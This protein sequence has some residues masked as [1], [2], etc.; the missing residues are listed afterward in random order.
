MGN[1]AL[2]PFII[3]AAVLAIVWYIYTVCLGMGGGIHDVALIHLICNLRNTIALYAKPKNFLY[4][5]SSFLVNKPVSFIRWV[6]DITVRQISAKRL[7]RLSL[8]FEH[9]SDFTAGVLGIKFVE[10]ID[11]RRH[12]VLHLVVAVHAIIDGNKTDVGIGKNHLRVHPDFQVITT[13]AA[14]VLHN[15]GAYLALIHQRHQA[16]PVRPVERGAA[17]AIIDE[18]GKVG[19]AIVSSVLLQNGLLIFYAVAVPL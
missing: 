16:V 1:C 2:A 9:S 6:F 8:G 15:N 13:E 18:K 7:A 3:I 5:I 12:V 4:H 17:V 19:E 14:H 11:E 10:N